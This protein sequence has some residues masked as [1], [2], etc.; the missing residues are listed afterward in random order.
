MPEWIEK[1]VMYNVM[2]RR[3][4]VRDRSVAINR[5]KT[6]KAAIMAKLS[7]AEAEQA[8][9]DRRR[10]TR[11]KIVLGAAVKTAVNMGRMD[12]ESLRRLLTENLSPKDLAIFGL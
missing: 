11:E 6:K 10:L 12:Q 2:I 7:L 4:K 5:L 8:K 1:I 3:S 9:E